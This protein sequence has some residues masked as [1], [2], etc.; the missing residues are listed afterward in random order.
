MPPSLADCGETHL[1]DNHW[2][3]SWST[4]RTTYRYK[5][6]ETG[7][8][9]A[10]DPITRCSQAFQFISHICNFILHLKALASSYPLFCNLISFVP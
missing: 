6:L 9:A 5:N 4:D 1:T 3:A 8:R 7:L 2:L 10:S